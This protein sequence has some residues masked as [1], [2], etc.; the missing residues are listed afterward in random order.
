LYFGRK[1]LHGS[2]VSYNPNRTGLFVSSRCFDIKH[3][4][5]G[6]K[7]NWHS[8]KSNALGKDRLRLCTSPNHH[9]IDPFRNYVY[10]PN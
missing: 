2:V 7:D 10:I 5:G 6:W 3:G 8:T 4:R 1:T 9:H